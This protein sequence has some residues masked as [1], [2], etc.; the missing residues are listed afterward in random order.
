VEA[1]VLD[2]AA[3]PHPQAPRRDL[4]EGLFRAVDG[5][6][7]AVVDLSPPARWVAEYYPIE[8]AEERPDGTLRVRLMVGDTGWLRRLVL[9]QGGAA[10]VVEPAE[11]A[12]EV[13][14]CARRALTAYGGD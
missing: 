9:R 5:S 13:R 1:T 10:R 14:E 6:L 4:S 12:E 11:L 8:A 7:E 3:D 2:A